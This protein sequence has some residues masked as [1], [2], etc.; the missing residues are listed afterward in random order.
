MGSSSALPGKVTKADPGIGFSFAEN[1]AS[2]LPD[3][4]KEKV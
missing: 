1:K 2:R 3:R 4:T